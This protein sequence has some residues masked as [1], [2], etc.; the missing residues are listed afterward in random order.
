M[1][2]QSIA[3]LSLIPLL[4]VLAGCDSAKESTEPAEAPPAA[5]TA[6]TL[7]LQP[8]TQEQTFPGRVVAFRTAQIRPRVSGIITSMSFS[9]GSEIRPGQALFQIDPAPFRADVNSAAAA[10]EKARANYRQLQARAARSKNCEA[11]VLSASRTMRMPPPVPRRQKRRL[12]SPAPRWHG[13]SLIL[14]MPQ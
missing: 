3:R 1:F 7:A 11:V 12:Q 10:V 5:V 4:Y 8:V 13:V 6:K 9:R 2:N 14:V